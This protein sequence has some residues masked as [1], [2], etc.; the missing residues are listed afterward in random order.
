MR[1]DGRENNELRKITITRNYLKYP[2]GSVLVE[3][4]DTK[5]ICTAFV[6]EKVPIFMKGSGKGWITAEY[7]MLP[8]SNMQ[9]KQRDISKL[10]LDNRSAEIQRLVGRS[11]RSV[12]ELNKLGERT[13][14][15]DCDVIQA[16][17]GTRVASVTGSFI[18]LYDAI[19][20][21]LNNKLIQ[22]N[23]IRFFAAAVSVGIVNEIPVVDL[24]YAE[25]SRAI[26]DMN[27]VMTEDGSFIELQATGEERPIREVE[28]DQLMLLATNAIMEIIQ[29]QK[30]A[31]G[32]KA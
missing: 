3:F 8:G 31:L 5:V 23:P 30:E 28:M 27:V 29:I 26:A 10:K 4:G 32:L 25:D 2:Q 1:A 15:I 20:H 6:E 22:L 21:L 13:I 18:A 16:D 14:W 19:Q 11:L 7:N 17:G 24:C 12:V 9:R